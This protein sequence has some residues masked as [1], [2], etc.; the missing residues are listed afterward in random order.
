[1]IEQRKLKLMSRFL[2]RLYVFVFLA[3]GYSG[4][5]GL[6]GWSIDSW[7]PLEDSNP[8]GTLAFPAYGILFGMLWLGVGPLV[9]LF[10]SGL[11][12]GIT[13]KSYILG[14]GN[15]YFR[16][17]YITGDVGAQLLDIGVGLMESMSLLYAST[18]GMYLAVYLSE[19]YREGMGA[20]ETQKINFTKKVVVSFILA[21]LVVGLRHYLY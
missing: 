9:I 10:F 7:L 21:G 12:D 1:M 16:E 3:G 17:A 19:R 2:P 8:L 13:L 5:I 4:L 20:E 18:G 14:G 6:F 15:M 11:K